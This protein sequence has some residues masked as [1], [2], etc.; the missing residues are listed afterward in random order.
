MK[1]LGTDGSPYVRKARVAIAEKGIACDYVAASPRDPA[2]GVSI[3]NPLS[4]VP[5]LVLDNGEAVFDSSVIIE[6]VDGLA[7]APKLI[8]DAFGDRIAVKRWAALGDGIIDAAVAIMHDRRLPAEKRQG[9]DYEARQM[10]KIEAA[11]AFIDKSV[12]HAEFLHANRFTLA[13]AVCGAALGYLD[14]VLPEF[15]WRGAHASLKRSAARLAARPAFVAT[16]ALTAEKPP[17]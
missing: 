6:Y 16:A 3:A 9:P 4:K 17:R 14:R 2:S 12:A 7:Q 10:Q 15:D 8:P 1:L 13:D 11:L 5:T